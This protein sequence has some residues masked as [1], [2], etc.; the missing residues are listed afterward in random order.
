MG[1]F[2][3]IAGVLLI[4]SAIVII[5]V[6]AMQESK[7]S[8]LSAMTGK[9]DSYLSKNR[10]KTMEAKLV[11][12]TKVLSIAFFVITLALNLIIRYVK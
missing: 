6:I 10:G 12:I 3:I 4:V 5:F 9:T 7:Q 11:F 8:G 2:E 1:I